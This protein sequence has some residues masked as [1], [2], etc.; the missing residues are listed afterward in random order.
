MKAI[1]ISVNDIHDFKEIAS[2]IAEA[3]DINKLE[4]YEDSA[5]A[6]YTING[7]D[8]CLDF[9]FEIVS[10]NEHYAYLSGGKVY[11]KEIEYYSLGDV[12]SVSLSESHTELTD[13]EWEAFEKALAEAFK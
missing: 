6:Y 9:T 13:A 3:T 4:A 5:S 1:E 12:I 8:L 7:L 2:K 11:E 10:D